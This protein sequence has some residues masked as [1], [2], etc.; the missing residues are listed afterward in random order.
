MFPH[1]VSASI[2]VQDSWV[3]SMTISPTV[4]LMPRLQL[5]SPPLS[6]RPTRSAW[7]AGI[8]PTFRSSNRV[9]T[10]PATMS[11]SSEHSM[12]WRRY[13]S[14][15]WAGIPFAR[16]IEQI[17]GW[18]YKPKSQEA[19]I[20]LS[21][22]EW[23]FLAWPAI[24]LRRGSPRQTLHSPTTQDRAI[25]IWPSRRG[26]LAERLASA[27]GRLSF[28]IPTAN[29]RPISIANARLP[30]LQHGAQVRLLFTELCGAIFH[31]WFAHM[32]RVSSGLLRELRS[33]TKAASPLDGFL[34]NDNQL[35]TCS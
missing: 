12:L 17:S 33:S 29:S 35:R 1:S 25:P 23:P 7:L 26:R 4:R 24:P 15:T 10:P 8:W 31:F 34:G 21:L 14:S 9:S 20:R 11:A 6:L 27:P 30:A 18:L 5:H 3:D 22:Q 13:D 19:R 28:S 2:V 16:G 32:M